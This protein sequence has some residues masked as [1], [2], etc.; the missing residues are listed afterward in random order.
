M[1][2]PGSMDPPLAGDWQKRG[3]MIPAL[4]GQRKAR[5]ALIERI[6]TIGYGALTGVEKFQPEAH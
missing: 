6:Q 1:D 4:A 2:L 5:Y 3:A